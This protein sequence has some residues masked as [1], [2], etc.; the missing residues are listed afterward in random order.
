M[1]V[2]VS[3]VKY[4]ESIAVHGVQLS[5]VVEVIVALAPCNMSP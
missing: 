3:T 2:N 1:V 5:V 4:A